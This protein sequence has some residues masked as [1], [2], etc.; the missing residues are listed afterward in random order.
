M[1][2]VFV[3]QNLTS[4]NWV[5]LPCSTYSVGLKLIASVGFWD[6]GVESVPEDYHTALKLY[7]ATAGRCRCEVIYHPVLYQHIDAGS[8]TT[9]VVQRFQQGVRH[10]WGATD[11][12]YVLWLAARSPILPWATRARIVLTGAP[13]AAPVKRRSSP[14]PSSAGA[15]V[16]P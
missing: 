3:L 16:A 6:T 5:H 2:A 15:A 1:W 4:A 13:G 12:A 7:W 14:P 8:W 11:C 9:T 10:M